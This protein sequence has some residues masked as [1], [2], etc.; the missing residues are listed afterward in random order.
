MTFVTG[1]TPP[2]LFGLLS[3]QKGLWSLGN[4]GSSSLAA[5][6]GDRGGRGEGGPVWVLQASIHR[7][8]DLSRACPV[9]MFAQPDTLPG[10]KV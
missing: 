3:Q 6:G 1:V 10:A 5:G 4:L 2:V 7:D 8:Q 9:S